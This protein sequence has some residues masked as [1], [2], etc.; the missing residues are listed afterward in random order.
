LELRSPQILC[1][2]LIEFGQLVVSEHLWDPP[3]QIKVGLPNCLS[4]Q[5]NLINAYSQQLARIVS[6]S[7]K[8]FEGILIRL[9]GGKLDLPIPMP[10]ATL[11]CREIGKRE[12]WEEMSGTGGMGLRERRVG[13]FYI[14]CMSSKFK[15]RDEITRFV[16]TTTAYS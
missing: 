1:P 9:V 16:Y 12:Y 3:D 6:N 10:L 2:N 5:V 13:F 11:R 15:L 8:E 14:L 7:G 4:G